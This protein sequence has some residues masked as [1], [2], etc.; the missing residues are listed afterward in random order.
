MVGLENFNGSPKMWNLFYPC[1]KRHRTILSHVCV[2]NVYGCFYEYLIM[3]MILSINIYL[4]LCTLSLL[5]PTIQIPKIVWWA[6]YCHY[7]LLEKGQITPR[8]SRKYDQHWY[9]LV[10]TSLILFVSNQLGSVLLTVVETIL[11]S[12]EVNGP[13]STI[14]VCCWRAQYTSFITGLLPS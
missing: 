14:I 11:S 3:N 1:R 4:F 6:I 5:G 13:E 10:L 7:I 9:C 8:L 12:D 2:C